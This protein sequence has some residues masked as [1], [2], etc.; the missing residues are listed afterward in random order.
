MTTRRLLAALL[1]IDAVVIA[2]FVVAA[3]LEGAQSG[4]DMPKDLNLGRRDGIGSL[5]LYL[6]WLAIC[7][8]FFAAN[9]RAPS[10]WLKY[11]LSVFLMLLIDDWAE[12]HE[13]AGDML[14]ALLG[15][16]P[17]FGLDSD[18]IGEVLYL[19]PFG[20]L[21]FGLVIAALRGAPEDM[22]KDV[23]VLI[24]L[25]VLLAFFGVGVDVLAQ[26]ARVLAQDG[27]ALN[28]TLEALEDGGELVVGSLLLIQSLNLY[29]RLQ[30]RGA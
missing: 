24:A 9:W 17:A 26:A 6:K 14:V 5:Y 13:A 27:S 7:G 8:I 18:D 1:L 30:E 16:Q 28:I 3:W 29:R 19:I 11:L 4:F 2:S 12:I 23:S 25:I 22:K 10:A 21:C 15:L 20:A